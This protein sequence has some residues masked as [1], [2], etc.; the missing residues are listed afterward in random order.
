MAAP[1]VQ[2][3]NTS[4]G[5]GTVHTVNLPTGIV[6]GELILIFVHSDGGPTFTPPTGFT[7]VNNLTNGG[8]VAGAIFKKIADGSEGATVTFNTSASETTAHIAYRISGA[9]ENLLISAMNDDDGAGDQTTITWEVPGVSSDWGAE[10]SLFIAGICVDNPSRYTSTTGLTGY[11]NEITSTS[12]GSTTAAGKIGTVRKEITGDTESAS[13]WNTT[14]TARA[15]TF[16]VGIAPA[17]ASIPLTYK[18]I[19]ESGLSETGTLVVPKPAELNVGDL[20]IACVSADNNSF[21]TAITPPAGWSTVKEQSFIGGNELGLVG[22]YSKVADLADTQATNFTFTTNAGSSDVAY[23]TIM[24][25]IGYDPTNGLST[26]VSANSNGNT[27]DLDATQTFLGSNDIYIQVAGSGH[28]E[29][30]GT[31]LTATLDNANVTNT[32]RYQNGTSSGV[33]VCLSIWTGAWD[34]TGSADVGTT[35]GRSTTAQQFAALNFII[36][37]APDGGPTWLPRVMFI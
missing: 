35:F 8:A 32:N 1:Q 19:S 3:T 36:H 15:V 4:N 22:V 11:G 20:M 27:L 21:T 33:D 25:F 13:T 14:T 31:S 16:M 9:S 17:G 28:S 18:S 37:G 7:L 30:V 26:A 24:R 6:S 5:S 12:P 34:G 2:A 29:S 10:D 23:A